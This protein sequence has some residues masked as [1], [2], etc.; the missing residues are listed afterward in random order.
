MKKITRSYIG[1]SIKWLQKLRSKVITN[2]IRSTC[3]I[4]LPRKQNKCCQTRC[5]FAARNASYNVQTAVSSAPK[6]LDHNVS[7]SIDARITP[8]VDI[9]IHIS[10]E[11]RI[12]QNVL[13]KE[14]LA[15]RIILYLITQGNFHSNGL[16]ISYI[17]RFEFRARDVVFFEF[18]AIQICENCST[19]FSMKK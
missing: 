16:P 7:L 4:N 8:N 1:K 17:H 6:C 9:G 5:L 2:V 12:S 11:I 3:H 13:D 19:E 18:Y 10:H 14:F 15:C